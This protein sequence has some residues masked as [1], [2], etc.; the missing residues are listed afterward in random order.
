MNKHKALGH[1]K[2]LVFLPLPGE[3]SPADRERLRR[4]RELIFG[5]IAFVLAAVVTRVLFYLYDTG[6][7]LFLAIFSL[8]F[9]LLLFVLGI[10]IRNTLKLLLERRRGVL[11]SRLRTRLTLALVIMT[12]APCLLMFLLTAKFVQISVDFWFRD[13][14]TTSMEAALD[15]GRGDYERTGRRLIAN[16]SAIATEIAARRYTWDSPELDAYLNRKRMEYRLPLAGMLNMSK[17][18]LVWHTNADAAEAWRHGKAMFNWET[19]E[20]QGS[21]TI[22][23]SGMEDDYTVAVQR[24]PGIGFFVTGESMGQAFKA[25]LERV[26]TGAVEYKQLWNMRRTLKGMLYTGLSVLTLLIMLG[27]IWFGFRVAKEISAPVLALADAAQS[28]AKGDLDVRLEDYSGDEL[29]MLIRAFNSMAVD[30]GINREQVTNANRLLEKQ[31]RQIVQHSQYMETVLNN[32]TSGVIS[33]DQEGCITMINKS[34]CS[35]LDSSP[36]EL[37]G[38]TLTSLL[39]EA[40]GRQVTAILMQFKNRPLSTWQRNIAITLF[41][42][43]RRLL[44]SAAGLVTPEGENRGFVAVFEDVAEMEK[45]QRM[46]AWREVARRIAHEIKNPLTPIKLSA[47]RLQRKF[48]SLVDDP[49]FAQSTNL[50][51]D[52]VESLQEMVQEFSAFAT[53]PEV[54]PKPG[55]IRPLLLELADLYKNSHSAILWETNVPESLPILPADKNALRRVFMNILGNAVDAVEGVVSPCIH[56]GA[57]VDTA[58]E[59]ARISVSDNGKGLSEQ[60]RSRLFEPYFS[61]K[62]GGTGLGLTIVRSIISDHKGYIRADTSLEGGMI[63]T[64]ELPLV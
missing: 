5:G 45:M 62:K 58:R 6:S 53:L 21:Q 31:N 12:L 2:N 16:G 19:L 22:L 42:Q 54:N 41:N 20:Q 44:V 9:L 8:N 34:A 28:I 35:M 3:I 36:A 57:E 30:L 32:I 7:A 38:K 64:V 55:D 1:I 47:Q 27:A 25:K 14:I 23:V 26:A 17:T 61:R 52:Q 63:I 18:E 40:M 60:D 51:V 46:A 56:I 4:R 24:L 43:E 33:A 39:P 49:A 48:G 50:I 37:V 10:V 59:V 15:V 13:Q 11:G 29:G